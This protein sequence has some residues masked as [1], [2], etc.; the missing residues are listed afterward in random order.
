[1]PTS[2]VA[3]SGSHLPAV[4]TRHVQR[5]PAPHAAAEPTRTRVIPLWE[6]GFII[7]LFVC[8][9]G[10]LTPLFWRANLSSD[11]TEANPLTQ[12][13]FFSIYIG[14]IVLMLRQWRLALTVVLHSWLLWLLVLLAVS[15]VAWTTDPSLTVRRSLALV[16][17]TVVGL[18][19]AT[20]LDVREQVRYLMLALLGTAVLS[21]VAGIVFPSDAILGGLWRGVF[22]HKNVLGRAMMLSCVVAGMVAF[23]QYRWRAVAWASIVISF[24]GILLSGS[25]TALV[26]L[27]V[28]LITAPFFRMLRWNISISVPLLLMTLAGGSYI[29]VWLGTYSD[30][31]LGALGKDSSLTGRTELWSKVLEMIQR[32]PWYGYGY[33]GF[34]QGWE[35]PSAEVWDFVQWTPAHS[36]FG[37]MDLTLD[38]GLVGLTIFLVGYGISFWRAISFTAQSGGSEH[39]WPLIYLIFM[40]LYNLTESA[41]LA[42]N[43]IFWLLYVSVFLSLARW[44][45]GTRQR[46]RRQTLLNRLPPHQ[47]SRA[48]ARLLQ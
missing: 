43:S 8:F 22:V 15:S 37:L 41:I 35:G 31:I 48:V 21:I 5:T 23:S 29:M 17:T 11:P 44:R 40:L 30:S 25:R 28:I 38:L 42:R 9:S 7:M 26:V 3:G 12:L 32:H 1:M 13:I 19:L 2:A 4:V 47:R 16:G 45:A 24:A 34:W 27:I 14:A 33:A 46:R 39:F 20:R 10:A 18:Y 36:H 6:R